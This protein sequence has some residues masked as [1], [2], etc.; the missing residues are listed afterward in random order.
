MSPDRSAL[1]IAAKGTE[2]SKQLWIL[3]NINKK[4]SYLQLAGRDAF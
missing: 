4:R 3:A 2:M 1:V